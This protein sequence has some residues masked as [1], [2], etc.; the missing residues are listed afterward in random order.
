[1]RSKK[2]FSFN[3]ER[4]AEKIVLEGFPNGTIDYSQMYLVA[5]Y[6]RQSFNYG[7]IRLER[8]L[9]KFCK[10]QD[11]NFNPVIDSEAIRKWVKSAMNYN[12]RK[13]ESI[14]ISDKEIETLKEIENPRDRRILFVTLVLAKA[15]KQ[16][17]T[18][19]NKTDLK[20]SDNYY[21]RYNNL[22]DITRLAKATNISEID[23]T[24]IFHKYRKYFIFYSPERE[25]IRLEYADKNPETKNVIE[26]MD[27]ILEYYEIFFGKKPTKESLKNCIVCGKELVK[28]SNRQKTCSVTCA[29]E[30]NRRRVAKFRSKAK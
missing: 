27:K 13:I 12:L 29:N 23:L 22:L 10:A 17:N 14:S 11:K 16:R 20:V 1:M 28:K 25:L 5:K 4:D 30:L 26:D 6:F 24:D 21:I 8:E 19:R 7:E 9:I 2:T 3:E 15:L 18:R